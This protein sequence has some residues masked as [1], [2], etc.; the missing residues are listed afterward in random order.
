M[1]LLLLLNYCLLLESIHGN[2]HRLE[3]RLVLDRQRRSGR[4]LQ[5]KFTTR[6][7]LRP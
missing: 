5:H 4:S 7:N 6:L 2:R 1:L 3:W